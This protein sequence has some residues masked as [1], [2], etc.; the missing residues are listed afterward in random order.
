MITA[1]SNTLYNYTQTPSA[2]K[3]KSSNFNE[4]LKSTQISNNSKFLDKKE[5]KN[6]DKMSFEFIKNLDKDN[7]LETI[8]KV[9]SDLPEDEKTKIG[10]LYNLANLTENMTLNKVLFDNAKNMTTNETMNYFREKG[11]ETIQY[12]KSGDGQIYIMNPMQF[13]EYREHHSLSGLGKPFNTSFSSTKE[14]K[15]SHEE[16]FSF[17]IDMINS[18]KEGM[19]KYSGDLNELFSNTYNEYSNLLEKYNNELRKNMTGKA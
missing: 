4:T 1:T 11:S 12:K 15:L 7:T 16:A 18:S 10:F 5:E 6:V 17:L 3:A 8:D 9:Y 14:T 19:E 13:K 2:N